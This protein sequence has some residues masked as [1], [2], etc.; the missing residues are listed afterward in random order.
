MELSSIIKDNCIFDLCKG[1]KNKRCN[2]THIPKNAFKNEIVKYINTPSLIPGM[3]IDVDLFR[4]IVAKKSTGYKLRHK[5]IIC[6]YYI[7]NQNCYNCSSGRTVT[8]NIKYFDH[9]I[10]VKICYQNFT[11]CEYTC[12]WGMHIDF[13]YKNISNKLKYSELQFEY[14]PVT[15]PSTNKSIEHFPSLSKKIDETK[16]SNKMMTYAKISSAP[17]PVRAPAPAPVRKPAPAPAPVRE[18]APAPASV[19]APA[20]VRAPEHVSVPKKRWVVHDR[21]MPFTK[22]DLIDKYSEILSSSKIKMIK[23]IDQLQEENMN[24]LK[25]NINLVDEMKSLKLIPRNSVSC[26]NCH[27]P[28]SIKRC[29]GCHIKNSRHLMSYFYP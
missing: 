29:K 3:N 22:N 2:R 24:F 5:I 9:I 28:L 6:L 27:T 26:D 19:R 4:K 21:K 15:K 20:P 23:K 13:I 8:I 25:R 18:P 17:A 10:P 12:I 1:C 16:P 14:L 11:K 7:T